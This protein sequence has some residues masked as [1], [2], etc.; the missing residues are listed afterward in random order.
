[1]IRGS[2]LGVVV[3][4][5]GAPAW[6]GAAPASKQCVHLN[7]VTDQQIFD[8]RTILFRED[9]RWYANDVGP[10]CG[11]LKPERT[12]Q[13]QTPSPTL[14]VGDLVRISRPSL[15][16]TYGSCALGEFTRVERRGSSIR[17]R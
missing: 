14:C 2:A 1:M 9:R 12:L 8:A 15:N 4:I 13:S 3:A 17:G 10:N 6:A 5:V 7:R 11:L 16:V